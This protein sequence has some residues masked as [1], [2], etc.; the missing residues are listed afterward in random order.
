MLMGLL[1]AVADAVVVGAGT[2]R[3]A[4][5]QHIWTADYI[6]PRLAGAYQELGAA[7]GK[8]DPPLNVVV[9][10][11][12]EIDTD[13][14][15]FCTGEVPVL[16]VTTSAGKERQ[17][18]RELPPSVRVVAAGETAPISARSVLGAIAGARNSDLVLIEAGPRLTGD[19]IAERLLD[20]LFLTIAPQVVGRDD[21]L[22]RPGFVA[23]KR[24]APECPV[25]GTLAGVN[26]G[27][28]HLFL[29]YAF[30]ADHRGSWPAEGAIAEHSPS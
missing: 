17:R 18:E 1:R 2:L 30:T 8:T 24:F 28:D 25:W 26:R 20:E 23:G 16:I 4:S 29:R 3:E 22:A 6:Y 12:G 7:M 11:S 19:F 15:L 5:P 13:R 21:S 27:G 10:A 14:R 9:T